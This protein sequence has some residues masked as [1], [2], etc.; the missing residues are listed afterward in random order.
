MEAIAEKIK[1]EISK[2]QHGEFFWKKNAGIQ[3]LLDVLASSLADEFIETAKQH[4][5][6]FKQNGGAK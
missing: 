1:Q 6:A 4:P 3:N 2:K 5:E